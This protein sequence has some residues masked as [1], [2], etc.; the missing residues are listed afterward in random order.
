MFNH[1]RKKSRAGGLTVHG[2]LRPGARSTRRD[3]KRGSFWCASPSATF[4][5]SSSVFPLSSRQGSRAS[6]LADPPAA[7]DDG[8]RFERIASRHLAHA[9]CTRYY[10]C[11]LSSFPRGSP[12]L[13]RRRETE[14]DAELHIVIKCREW[15]SERGR[16]LHPPRLPR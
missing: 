11:T 13:G 6:S 5:T 16:R 7:D 8:I 3:T 10:I 1:Q 12:L 15:C 4:L 9:R 14:R 2:V